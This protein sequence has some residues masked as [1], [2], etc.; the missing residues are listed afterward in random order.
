MR[1]LL[2]AAVLMS[3][4]E[5]EGA[6][7]KAGKKLEWDAKAGRAKKVERRWMVVWFEEDVVAKIERDLISPP[8]DDEA[9]S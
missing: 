4:C 7:E 8:D 2:L 6:A 3:G 1:R 9:D 5:E